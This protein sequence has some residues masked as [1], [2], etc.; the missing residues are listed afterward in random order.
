VQVDSGRLAEPFW[1]VDSPLTTADDRHP[2]PGRP[3]RDVPVPARG[4]L[5]PDRPVVVPSQLARE[6]VTVLGGDLPVAVHRIADLDGT[7][8]MREALDSRPD[9]VR[10]LRPDAHVAAVLTR[11][12]DVAFSG[13]SAGLPPFLLEFSGGCRLHLALDAMTDP[14]R[15]RCTQQGRP[16]CDRSP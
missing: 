11:A 16:D 9:E 1:Y 7:P 2:F 14:P 8:V 6:G 15:R 4:V 10:V 13:R 12:A 3:A 5:V